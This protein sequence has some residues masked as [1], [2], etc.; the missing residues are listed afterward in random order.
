M[1]WFNKRSY[2]LAE[3]GQSLTC[4]IADNA[5]LI[6]PY[7]QALTI[8]NN[9]KSFIYWFG[10]ARKE[11]GLF[12]NYPVTH[13]TADLS[14]WE[15]LFNDY[16]FLNKNIRWV[17]N[18]RIRD[19]ET[20]VMR[21]PDDYM[22]RYNPSYQQTDY[23]HG[24][25]FF[26]LANA[27][28][29]VYYLNQSLTACA[30]SKSTYT[31]LANYYISQGVIDVGFEIFDKLMLSYPHDFSICMEAGSL[32]YGIYHLS[33]EKNMLIE[34]DKMFDR[35]ISLNPYCRLEVKQLKHQADSMYAA[36]KNN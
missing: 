26:H 20:R 33:G 12:A 34:A 21:M 14:N 32:R 27:D 1:K 11:P 18:Y 30:E 10:M 23:E 31:L 36:Q 7:A 2:N 29:C 3:A 19:I 13:I 5:V 8:D 28:S 24:I 6:G 4:D 25:R 22:K 35:A 17:S 15:V 16:P 9:I